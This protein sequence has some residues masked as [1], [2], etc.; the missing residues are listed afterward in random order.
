MVRFQIWTEIRPSL[1]AIEELM[2]VRV[3]EKKDDS[4]NC[5]R[6]ALKLKSSKRVYENDSEDEFYDVERSNP[7]QGDSSVDATSQASAC[8]WKEE[9]ELLVRGGAPMALR[10]E[11]IHLFHSALVPSLV[12]VI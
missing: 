8:P 6:E 2:S 11:V 3:K 7:V 1:R 10:G 12:A 5:E 4:S 9:L